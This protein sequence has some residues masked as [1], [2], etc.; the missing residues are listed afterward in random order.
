MQEAPPPLGPVPSVTDGGP[1]AL[2]SAQQMEA[3]PHFV[4]LAWEPGVL[5]GIVLPL[6]TTVR[7][8]GVTHLMLKHSHAA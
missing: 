3:G 8:T 7:V 5:P 4:R 1:R 6:S 2:P